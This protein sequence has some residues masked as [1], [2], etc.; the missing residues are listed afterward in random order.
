MKYIKFT[1]GTGLCGTDDECYLSFADNYTTKDLDA[2][3]SDLAFDNASSHIDIERDY[4][5]YQEEYDTEE[6]YEEAY[7]QAEASWDEEVWYEWEEVTE[8]EWRENDGME[9]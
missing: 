1:Y 4:G 8:E 2:Y 5:I 9:G 7:A 3:A 6:E